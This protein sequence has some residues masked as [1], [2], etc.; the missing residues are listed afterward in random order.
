MHKS[1]FYFSL[2]ED[3]LSLCNL[4]RLFSRSLNIFFIYI[5]LGFRSELFMSNLIRYSLGVLYLALADMN[6]FVHNWLLLN[7]DSF[8]AQRN[9]NFFLARPNLPAGL[10]SGARHTFDHTRFSCC[11][12]L[13]LLLLGDDLF[14]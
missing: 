4:S 5:A 9:A 11:W 13:N 1:P 14:S 12:Y 10:T 6:L 3:N 2:C 7:V 8:F